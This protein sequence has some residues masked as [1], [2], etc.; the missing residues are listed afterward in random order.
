M[1][2]DANP[3]PLHG[4]R[5]IHCPHYM[6]CSGYARATFYFWSCEMCEYR[7]ITQ[8]DIREYL[9]FQMG[10]VDDREDQH[11]VGW[12]IIEEE[13]ML[14]VNDHNN[15]QNSEWLS[16][17]EVSAEYINYQMAIV[18]N[19]GQQG[20]ES[21]NSHEATMEYIDYQMGFINDK[22]QNRYDSLN[23]EEMMMGLLD[24]HMLIWRRSF[25]HKTS[26]FP[27]HRQNL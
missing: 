26:H 3:F 18:N 17:E 15:L 2:P 4:V 12:S 16:I 9:N 25:H 8:E 10:V 20:S 5:N 6:S 22:P 11:R 24:Y 27:I 7:Q 21:F 1:A 19:R 13:N 14:Y 23:S